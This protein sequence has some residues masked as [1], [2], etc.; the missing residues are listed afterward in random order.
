MLEACAEEPDTYDRETA[1]GLDACLFE[2]AS[3]RKAFTQ[4]G[5]W[6]AGNPRIAAPSNIL[7]AAG[8]EPGNI[9]A[10]KKGTTLAALKLAE[11]ERRA[12]ENLK[13]AKLAAERDDW[14]DVRAC[15]ERADAANDQSGE[16]RARTPSE[17]AMQWAD[18]G[19]LV[20]MATGIDPLDRACLGGLPIPWR[21]VIVGAPS[22]GKTA[23][24]TI[25]ANNIA[26]AAAAEG[27]CV[28]MLCSDEG[29]EDITVRLAQI[30]GYSVRDVEARD[31]RT[32]VSL[33]EALS[34]LNVRLY[35]SGWTIEAVA[36]DVAARCAAE[37][38]KGVLFI[39]SLQTVCSSGSVIA[40]NPREIVEAN[41]RAVRV[42]SEHHRLLVISTSEA[43]RGAYR[44]GQQGEQDPIASGAETRAIEFGAQT[45]LY[46]ST[47]KDHADVI[48][49]H[50]AK[51]RRAQTR[52]DFWLRLD[53]ERQSVEECEKP[54]D[55][56]S[57]RSEQTDVARQARL[58]NAARGLI[59]VLLAKP[60][61]GSREVRLEASR[62][63]LGGNEM[64]D[65]AMMMLRTDGLDGYRLTNRASDTRPKWFVEL[66]RSGDHDA[67]N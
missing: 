56:S 54:S 23:T 18:E 34:A 33:A 53:R 66:T 4:L 9:A 17:I 58:E 30:A 13:H 20:R 49:V 43:N 16:R 11:R 1:Q 7:I 21:V 50:V 45:L 38:S 28:G 48:K 3:H 55:T 52:V 63:R 27:A 64:V 36:A 61:L 62:G 39:D 25:I 22:A 6:Y 51:N 5:A 19:P 24:G 14:D 10:Y 29:P 60:G 40:T 41:V 2:V 26:R 12:A 57:D 15:L 67:H 65:A 35:D 37:K 59:R 47:P 31:P 44:N 42:A 32:M 46:M 8:V